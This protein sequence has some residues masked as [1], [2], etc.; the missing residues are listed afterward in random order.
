MSESNQLRA[1][2]HH[3][4]EATFRIVTPMFLG[5]ADQGPGD[6]IRPPSVKGALRFWWR[7]L[8][9]GRFD[10]ECSSRALALN[11]LHDEE[12]RLFGGSAE[13]GGQ[14]SF[15]LRAAHGRL[16]CTR[17]GDVH[18]NFSRK[19]A[20]RYLGY[21]LM[22][23]YGRR[24]GSTKDGQLERPC[25][26]EDQTFAVTFVFRREI[27]A[28]VREALIAFGLLGSLGSRARHGMGSV[29]L[30]SIREGG[31]ETWS[32]PT[33][34]AAYRERIQALFAGRYRL[35]DEPPF[36][37]FSQAASIDCLLAAATPYDALEAFGQAMLMYRS[38][39]QSSKGNVLPGGGVSEMRFQSDHDWS[40][41]TRPTNFHPRRVAFGLPHNYGKTDNLKVNADKHERRASPLFFHVHLVGELFLGIAIHLPAQF[42]P[43]GEKINAGGT[44]VGANVDPTVI[45][46]F[47]DGQI[48][49]PSSPGAKARFPSKNK[50]L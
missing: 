21:G 18:F 15:L 16:L 1:I 32:A 27:D 23:A 40:K 50:V 14:G 11:L 28:S 7:A 48:G 46:D 43:H 5:G 38:W 22:V 9:W 12:V 6:G 30:L 33:D 26:N 45:I 2:A 37:A 20:A 13:Q 3:T 31:R 8:N 17:K 41:G 47:L 34:E 35:T 19:S 44:R 29:A 49:P 10:S 36:T 42:L 25:L 4:L 39:G 24:D